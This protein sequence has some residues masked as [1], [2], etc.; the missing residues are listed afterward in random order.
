[1]TIIHIRS[2]ESFCY[3]FVLAVYIIENYHLGVWLTWTLFPLAAFV[4]HNFKTIYSLHY[5]TFFL[6]DFSSNA[7]MFEFFPINFFNG[8]LPS[9][10]EILK[11]TFL[12]TLHVVALTI[13]RRQDWNLTLPLCS[14]FGL[15]FWFADWLFLGI[16]LICLLFPLLG[17]LGFRATK[18]SFITVDTLLLFG[19][20]GFHY[21]FWFLNLKK[22]A[23]LSWNRLGFSF[24]LHWS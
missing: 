4:T 7:E 17:M 24:S 12:L 22:N 13:N 19:L 8:W 5:P 2:C 1:M 3:C 9:V 18:I 20:W 10:F 21:T 16:M 15:K 6:K 11:S 14:I 23:L